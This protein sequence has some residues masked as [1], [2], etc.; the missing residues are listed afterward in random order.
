MPVQHTL[1]TLNKSV[2]QWNISL[3]K[4]VATILVQYPKSQ[5]STATIE[6]GYFRAKAHYLFHD[7]AHYVVEHQLRLKGFWY[8]LYMGLSIEQLSDKAVIHTLE[9]DI[10]VSEIWTRT[11]QSLD[12]GAFEAIDGALAIHTELMLMKL[13]APA[14]DALQIDLEICRSF[15]AALIG[16]WKALAEGEFLYL[17]FPFLDLS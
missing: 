3:R 2:A 4:E 10:W 12:S 9:R 6:N 14:I 11:L 8:Y 13:T 16:E 5:A 1:R 15:Y 17:P 7:L